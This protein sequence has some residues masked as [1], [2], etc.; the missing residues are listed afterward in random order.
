[1]ENKYK[2]SD[3]QYKI[4]NINQQID[5]LFKGIKSKIN[6]ISDITQKDKFIKDLIEDINNCL[7]TNNIIKNNN[8]INYNNL[9]NIEDDLNNNDNNNENEDLEQNEE[10]IENELL[11]SYDSAN[12]NDSNPTKIFHKKRGKKY[13]LNSNNPKID[14][15]NIYNKNHIF[16]NAILNRHHPYYL[17]LSEFLQFNN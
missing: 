2:N 12:L 15:N 8:K 3:F 1:M 16:N 9:I 13:L 5:F 11:S 14:T 10:I 7:D 6:G 4:D 17:K